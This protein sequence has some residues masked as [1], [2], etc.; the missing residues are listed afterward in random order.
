MTLS[1]E[2][3]QSIEPSPGPRVVDLTFPIHEGMTTYPSA[4][5]P[6]VEITQLGRHG[7]EN[8]ETRKITLGTHTGTHCD[9]PLHFVPRG[10]TADRLPLESLI[11]PAMVADL[12]HLGALHRVEASHLEALLGDERPQR[13]ILRY[14]WSDHWGTMRYYRE[15]PY[16]A[17][18]TAAWVVNRGIRLLAMDTPTPDDPRTGPLNPP[19]SPNHQLLLGAGVILVEYLCNLKELRRRDVELI[20]CPMKIVGA[21][22]SPVRCVALER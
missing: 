7:I 14:D 11:G 4:N 13:L 5:H 18:D 15:H 1:L 21:D 16:L 6:R 22:G 3:A 8:R 17:E 19:D 9:A 12:T 10:E 20:V 2:R